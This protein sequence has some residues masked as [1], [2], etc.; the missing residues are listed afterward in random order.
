[1]GAAEPDQDDDHANKPGQQGGGSDV[2]PRRPWLARTGSTDRP[3]DDRKPPCPK[4][5]KA[6]QSREPVPMPPPPIEHQHHP[7]TA[8]EERYDLPPCRPILEL[9]DPVDNTNTEQDPRNLINAITAC[10][11]TNHLEP[12]L[13]PETA[14]RLDL[15][16]KAAFK[17]IATYANSRKK[18]SRSWTTLNNVHLCRYEKFAEGRVAWNPDK[19][20][21]I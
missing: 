21:I 6:H 15:A 7:A 11:G 2:K 20:E 8:S 4:R 18:R 9:Y 19:V 14:R 1:M 16:V 10:R 17:T 3:H 12:P 5:G 13:G